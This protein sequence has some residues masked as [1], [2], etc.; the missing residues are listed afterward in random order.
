MPSTEAQKRACKKWKETNRE[1]YNQQQNEY[2]KKYY[3]NNREAR[4]EYAKQ[5]REK[6]L[7][8][9]AQEGE[10]TPKGRG[11]PKKDTTT[12]GEN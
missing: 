10:H 9:K 7:L 3:L 5:Y 4:L 11:R 12:L 6:K 8:E 2:T 1:Y